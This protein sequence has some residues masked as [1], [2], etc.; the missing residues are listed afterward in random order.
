MCY[1][2]NAYSLTFTTKI[3]HKQAHQLGEICENLLHKLGLALQYVGL[4]D[5]NYEKANINGLI[6]ELMKHAFL[7]AD[8]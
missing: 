6:T 3:N 4:F 1:K 7:M 2:I 5:D 8:C